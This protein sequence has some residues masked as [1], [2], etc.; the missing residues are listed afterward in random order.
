[1]AQPPVDTI[2]ILYS[3]EEQHT[4]KQRTTLEENHLH[5][6]QQPIHPRITL[7]NTEISE[8]QPA[9]DPHHVEQLGPQHEQYYYSNSTHGVMPGLQPNSHPDSHMG[10]APFPTVDGF[11]P[12]M[13]GPSSIPPPTTIYILTTGNPS[14]DMPSTHQSTPVSQNSS[15]L[16][17]SIHSSQSSSLSRGPLFGSGRRGPPGKRESISRSGSSRKGAN[18]HFLRTGSWFRTGRRSPSDFDWSDSESEDGH[19]PPARERV[20]TAHKGRVLGERTAIDVP[21][22]QVASSSSSGSGSGSGAGS[23]S[24]LTRTVDEKRLRPIE[25]AE[26]PIEKSSWLRREHKKQK[27][28]RQC[29]SLACILCFIVLGVIIAFVFR[30]SLFGSKSNHGN[31]EKTIPGGGKGGGGPGDTIEAFYGINKTITPTPGLAKIFYGL[32]Y[33]PRGS[34]EPNCHNSFPEIV[35]DIKVLSQLTT[36]IR[37]YGMGCDQAI[38]VLKAIEFLELADMQVVLTIWVDHNPRTSWEKQSKAFWDVI[39]RDVAMLPNQLVPKPIPGSL[40]PAVSRVIGISVGNEVLFRN[41]DK[42]KPH[43]HVP[44]ATLMRYINEV[45]RG[46]ALRSQQAL[47][48]AKYL[49]VID[50]DGNSSNNSSLNLETIG[51]TKEEFL[52]MKNAY[53]GRMSAGESLIAGTGADLM[54]KARHLADIPVFSSDLGRNAHQIVSAVDEVMSN[55]HPFFASQLARKA[56]DWTILNYLTETVRAADGKPA[57]ISEVGWP[58]GPVSEVWGSAVPS[59][60][61]LQVFVNDWVCKA[62]RLRIPY[63]F[64][65]AFDEPWKRSINPREALWGLMDT[66]RRLKIRLPTCE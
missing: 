53:H 23:A 26:G 31:H 50:A 30:D 64:F 45:R 40:S 39:D 43:E 65:E 2:E 38:M 63:Y 24:P 25:P 56:A 34:Q 21:R 14:P 12:S 11:V 18:N 54:S 8:I 7:T 58:S 17:T 1:M 51:L 44:V 52:Q 35:E 48:Y 41:E 59:V 16:A 66:E 32:D 20:A 55:I 4:E 9:E 15:S 36:R 60:D 42:T 29:V 13:G 19:S 10:V 28:M 61:N 62:N 46:L 3:P 47:K 6:T 49:A 37:L 27:Q 22:E 5:Q 33:T 57:V